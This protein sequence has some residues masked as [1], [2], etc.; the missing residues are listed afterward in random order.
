MNFLA[1][2]FLSFNDKE[3]MIGNF[4]ADH[5]KGKQELVF[6]DN[7]RKGIRLHRGID[8]YTDS[9]PV[10]EQSKIRLRPGFR[11]YAPVVTD[12]FY[13]HFLATD[14]HEFSSEPLDRFIEEFYTSAFE[15]I[16]QLPE[17][18]RKMLPVMRDQNWLGKY[19]TVEGLHSILT[20][21]SRRTRFESGMENAAAELELSVAGALQAAAINNPHSIVK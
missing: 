11:K 6:P 14:W 16:D 9:H 17:F 1:H 3:V 19:R 13:D 2:L 20:S 18:T 4:I 5:V 12:V 7:I 8:N 21:M 10:V 15:R